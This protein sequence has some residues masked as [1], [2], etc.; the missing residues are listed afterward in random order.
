MTNEI[1]NHIHVDSMESLLKVKRVCVVGKLSGHLYMYVLNGAMCKI[2]CEP[3]LGVL[4]RCGYLV[5]SSSA[6]TAYTLTVV[7]T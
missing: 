7:N 2:H 1:Y 6:L 3:W 5:Y 4:E